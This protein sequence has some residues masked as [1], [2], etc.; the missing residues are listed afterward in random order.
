MIIFLNGASS[1]GKSSIAKQLQEILEDGYLHIGIDTFIGLMPDKSNQLANTNVT[2]E[3]FYWR[4][5][6]LNGRT[7]YKIAKGAYGVQV[8][9]VYRTTITHL[10][11]SGLNV[12]VD[13]ICDGQDEMRIWHEVLSG[14][15]CLFVGIFCDDDE[16]ERREKARGDRQLGT[17][18]EQSF[19]VHQGIQ[20]ALTVDTSSQSV[21]QCAELIKQKLNDS[22]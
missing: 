10:A 19:R 3:G 17:A 9:D 12:I 2:A 7:I 21:E 5:T 16:L 22:N 1:S 13:D 8:N 11:D 15:D 4:P 6:T 20:Y 18:I 14:Y